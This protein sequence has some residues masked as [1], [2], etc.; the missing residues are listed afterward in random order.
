[1]VARL[2]TPSGGSFPWQ[3][4][5]IARNPSPQLEL[6]AIHQ[7]TDASLRPRKQY[8]RLRRHA[9]GSATSCA[10]SHGPEERSPQVLQVLQPLQFFSGQ[11]FSVN[12]RCCSRSVPQ[13][14]KASAHKPCSKAEIATRFHRDWYRRDFR[15]GRLPDSGCGDSEA[16]KSKALSP[17]IRR[18]SER[19]CRRK[20]C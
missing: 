10:W 16:T 2:L 9:R 13:L 6:P 11:W 20:Y 17:A 4:M 8:F 18:L 5:C 12:R 19:V 14:V 15:S 7:R 3:R 1:V